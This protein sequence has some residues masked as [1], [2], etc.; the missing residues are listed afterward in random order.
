[1]PDRAHPVRASVSSSGLIIRLALLNK[2]FALGRHVGNRQTDAAAFRTDH[3]G[4][5]RRCISSSRI[6]CAAHDTISRLWEVLPDV[7]AVDGLDRVEVGHE[8]GQQLGV[9]RLLG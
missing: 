4:A 8:I 3:D 1:M 7:L 2:P 5:G 9:E 6:T